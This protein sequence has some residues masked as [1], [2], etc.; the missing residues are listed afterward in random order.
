MIF[1]QNPD[2][3]MGIY[4]QEGGHKGFYGRRVPSLDVALSPGYC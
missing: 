2:K 3:E 4:N 1:G